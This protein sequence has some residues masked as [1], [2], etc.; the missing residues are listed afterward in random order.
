VTL[1]T[2][3]WPWPTNLTRYMVTSNHHAKYLYQRSLCSK[4]IVGTHTHRQ[5][6]RLSH[7]NE[8]SIRIAKGVCNNCK[9]SFTKVMTQCTLFATY[10]VLVTKGI[11]LKAPVVE[12]NVGNPDA[13]NRNSNTGHSSVFTGVPRQ[14]V[15]LPFLYIIIISQLHRHQHHQ[16]HQQQH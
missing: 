8:C 15:I 12:Y 2:Y 10:S 16:H 11:C 5:K 1:D 6:D 13:R 9:L 3:L 7:R 4:V 14:F